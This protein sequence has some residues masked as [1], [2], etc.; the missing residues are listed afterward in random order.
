MTP[1]AGRDLRQGLPGEDTAG[2]HGTGGCGT[3]AWLPLP[4]SPAVSSPQQ[5]AAP[6]VSS[7]HSS[8]ARAKSGSGSC[9]PARRWC[10]RPR[11]R[12]STPSPSSRRITGR[13][14][15]VCERGARGYLREQLA[16]DHAAVIDGHGDVRV[17]G[18]AVAE[19]AVGV[20]TGAAAARASAIAATS[21][22][23]SAPSGLGR[24][25]SPVG[26]GQRPTGRRTAYFAFAASST[27]CWLT[28]TLCEG[29][30]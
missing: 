14:Q 2:V 25:A 1:P 7:A 27:T 15:R 26:T 18:A 11:A 4:S 29:R 23:R 13:V 30:P 3:V 6:A 22:A 21:T 16:R 12:R 10:P 20:L 24:A 8:S 19:L 9:P 28:P 5:Y 17:T